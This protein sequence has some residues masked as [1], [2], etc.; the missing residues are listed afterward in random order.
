MKITFGSLSQFLHTHSFFPLILSSLMACAFLIFRFFYSGSY[1]YSN[2][3]WNLFLAWLPYIFSMLASSIYGNKPRRWWL[4]TFLGLLW[5]LFFPN[6]PY[7]VTDFYYLDPRPPVPLWF[8]ISLI[9]LFAFTGCFLAIASLRSIHIIIERVVGKVF[10]WLFALLSLGLASLGVYLGRFSRY[11]SW[12]LLFNA[13]PVF[14]EIV[15]NLFN[16][17]ENLSFIGFTMM[18]TTIL[19]VCYLMFMTTS[20]PYPPSQ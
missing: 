15:D 14:K 17:L 16:P 20:N 7:I 9:A 18:F 10:G 12:D 6:A 3:L 1:N 5:L 8:D 4:I 2:L 11:N 19:L 13:K